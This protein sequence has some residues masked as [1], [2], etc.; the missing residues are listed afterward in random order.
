[1]Q[2]SGVQARI[3]F[4]AGSTPG[5]QHFNRYTVK[6][7]KE[8]STGLPKGCF[9][10]AIF[11]I[12][13]RNS[14]HTCMGTFH[15]T[16]ELGV[17]GEELAARYLR[18]K[19]Y[20]ILQTNYCNTVGKRLGEIDIVA[21]KDRE[22]VFV[23]VK[24]RIGK[25]GSDFLPETSITREKLRKLERIAQCYLREK[26]SEERSYHFDALSVLYDVALKKAQIRHLEHIFI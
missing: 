13:E 25:A 26:R 15:L 19:G 9:F 23:E 16:S 6:K 7:E 8:N 11:R 21:E 2:R 22:L 14:L 20:K 10:V 1:M 18:D 3:Y 24:S 5:H 17:L 4:L 12:L